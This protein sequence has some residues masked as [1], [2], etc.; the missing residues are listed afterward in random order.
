MHTI[1]DKGRRHALGWLF[2]LLGVSVIGVASAAGAIGIERPRLLVPLVH[3]IESPVLAK[4]ASGAYVAYYS[5]GD[6]NNQLLVKDLGNAEPGMLVYQVPA[7]PN[8]SSGIGFAAEDDRR[9]LLWRPKFATQKD[10]Y[11]ARSDGGPF[12]EPQIINR[13]QNALIPALLRAGTGGLVVSAWHD[14][15]RSGKSYDIYLNVSQDGGKTFLPE[16]IQIS[17]NY[18]YVLHPSLL[19]EGREIHLFFVG[20]KILNKKKNS[21]AETKGDKKTAKK[22]RKGEPPDEHEYY[23]VHH[24]SLDGGTTWDESR[25]STIKS[26]TPVLLTPVRL[27]DGR[28]WLYFT[29]GYGGLKATYSDDGGKHWQPFVMPAAAE[30]EYIVSLSVSAARDSLY[31]A[32]TSTF[33]DNPT[34]KPDIFILQGRDRGSRWDAPRRLSSETHR[35]TQS[36]GPQ[37]TADDSGRVLVVWTDFRHIRGAIYLNYSTDFGVT[38]LA[39]EIPI[40]E[41][42]RHNDRLPQLLDLGGGRYEVVYRRYTDDRLT[43]SGLWGSRLTLAAP[44]AK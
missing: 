13:K 23:L 34:A 1:S 10:V 44:L 12:S 21:T 29:E 43:D 11:F 28:L 5:P 31:L 18:D 39:N 33:P 2:G 8:K 32:Y 9:Y 36:I 7:G 4:N 14:E 38:W 16:D 19:V 42:G 41:P 20:Q 22:T 27:S 15:R 17:R 6:A 24:R 37:I 40:G 25:I 30:G 26:Q 3:A 35:L